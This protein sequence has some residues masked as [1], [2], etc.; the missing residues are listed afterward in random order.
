MAHLP[1][2]TFQPRSAGLV[3]TNRA[4][5]LRPEEE[6]VADILSCPTVPDEKNVWT[7]WDKGWDAMRP[8]VRRNVVD[9]ARKLGP[10][11]WRVRVLDT[12]PGSPRHVT[13]FVDEGDL[14]GKF[15]DMRGQHKA[16][17]VRV[18]LLHAYGGFWY[19]QPSV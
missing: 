6:I 3:S 1:R 4:I 19:V 15:E 17:V 13:H 11:G 12:V 18:L 8:W 7:L 9:W 10:A 16:D 2:E 14:P 5:D